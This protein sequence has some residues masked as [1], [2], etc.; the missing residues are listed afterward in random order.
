MR[1][2]KCLLNVQSNNLKTQDPTFEVS[3][4]V[5]PYLNESKSTKYIRFIVED[6]TAVE[7]LH[8]LQ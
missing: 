2:V 1:V 7:L 3:V 4:T 6:V 8:L 5:H